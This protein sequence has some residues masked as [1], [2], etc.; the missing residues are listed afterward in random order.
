MAPPARDTWDAQIVS[1]TRE[2]NRAEVVLD[3]FRLGTP[4]TRMTIT[5]DDTQPRPPNAVAYSVSTV[6]L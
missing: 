4:V 2:A 3:I 6:P 5:A 1:V